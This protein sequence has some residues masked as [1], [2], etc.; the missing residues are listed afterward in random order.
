MLTVHKNAVSPELLTDIQA[1]FARVEKEIGFEDQ[2]YMD[3][4]QD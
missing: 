3:M 2:F 1:A 4:G